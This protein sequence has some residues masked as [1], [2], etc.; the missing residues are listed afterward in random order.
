METNNTAA[1]QPKRSQGPGLLSRLRPPDW[2]RSIWRNRKARTGLIILT[3]FVLIAIFAPVITTNDP[4]R[5]VGQPHQPPSGDYIFGTTRQ[6]QDVFSQIVR[7]TA[8][9]LAVGFGGGTFI[10]MLCI[11]VGV[12]AGYVGGIV[13][14]VLSLL[15]NVFLVLPGLPL[16]IVVAGWVAQPGPLT[17]VLVLSFTSWAYGAR[18]LRSQTL[19]LRNSEFVAAARV[20]GESTWRIV[21]FEILPNM[22]S[23]V[24]SAWIGAVVYVILTEATLSFIGLGNPNAVSWGTTLYWAQNN[25]A[26]LTNAWWTFVPPGVCIAL[27]GFSLTLVNYGIDEI[28]NPR[29]VTE[30]FGEIG[31]AALAGNGSRPPETIRRTKSGLLTVQGLVVEYH[32]RRGIVRAAN[33]VPFKIGKNEVLGLAG[34]SGCGKSTI[35]HAVIRVHKPPAYI[36][37]GAINFDGIDLLKMNDEK[38]RSFRWEHLSIVF[39][40]AMNALNPV[41]TVG[42]QIID[43]IQ[44]HKPTSKREA[45]ARARE[46]LEVMGIDPERIDSFPHQLSGGMRQ[47]AVIAIALALNPEL[48]IMDEPTTALDVVV[49]KSIMEEVRRLKTEFGF[50]ILFITHDLS[51]LVEFADRIGIMYAGE[52]VEVAPSDDIFNN[53]KHP[54]TRRLMNSFPTISGP[55][56]KL[57]GIPG[58]PPDLVDP[59]TGCRFHPRCDVAIPGLCEKVKPEL[60]ELGEN[61]T[62]AC[63][64]LTEEGVPA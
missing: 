42:D 32:T 34:E 54:Y 37:E 23:L 38:L 50:S 43:A 52:I 44:A 30:E 36:T 53:P 26:L 17:V 60:V 5:M 41:L 55:R 57:F 1:L 10:I 39:Q 35:A 46:L 58:S 4:N 12:T 21:L 31:Q 49:Q 61:H 64:L 28:T 22:T 51:L 6:G 20:S 13:D 7:G 16:I 40:S 63:H 24:V 2:M 27:V 33:K 45:R 59:P 18:V 47:R 8:T 9:S 25:Q 3:F 48:I 62:A 14:E 56:Q 19:V 11:L 15:A 29:L